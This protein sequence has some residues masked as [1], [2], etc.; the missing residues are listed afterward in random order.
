MSGWRQHSAIDKIAAR[1]K[2]HKGNELGPP[3]SHSTTGSWARRPENSAS[4]DEK[5][6]YFLKIGQFFWD[7]FR[8]FSGINWGLICP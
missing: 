1:L 7:I 3:V 4:S 5:S 6:G 2:A 8:L